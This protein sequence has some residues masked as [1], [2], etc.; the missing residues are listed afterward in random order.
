MSCIF[1][2]TKEL[3]V[4]FSSEQ[5]D[6]PTCSTPK[7]RPINLPSVASIEELRT[8]AFEELLRSFWDTKSG[9]HANG[10]VKHYTGQNEGA[11]S[12]RDARLPLTELCLCHVQH[13]Y[14][15]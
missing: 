10:D 5:V 11:Q 8:H 3:P 1:I 15:S 14:E 13:V 6:E 4:S 2:E 9:K 12:I 7:K